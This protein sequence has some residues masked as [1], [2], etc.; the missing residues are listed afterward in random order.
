MSLTNS[1][2]RKST[3]YKSLSWGMVNTQSMTLMGLH[4]GNCNLALLNLFK[5]TQIV[6]WLIVL[7]MNIR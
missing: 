4:L 7:K 5:L 6:I 2:L 3:A 1:A